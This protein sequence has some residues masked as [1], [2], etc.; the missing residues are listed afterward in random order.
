LKR[1]G[2]IFVLAASKKMNINLAAKIDGGTAHAC[3]K[4]ST[5]RTKKQKQ[6]INLAAKIDGRTRHACAWQWACRFPVCV[7]VCV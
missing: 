2:S 7:C 4:T 1:V 5:F 6:I 3:K